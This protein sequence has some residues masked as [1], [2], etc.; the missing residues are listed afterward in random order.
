MKKAKSYVYVLRPFNGWV[1]SN[2]KGVFA[3]IDDVF[4]YFG[5]DVII[6]DAHETIIGRENLKELVFEGNCG[7]AV[8]KV[9]TPAFSIGG[10]MEFPSRARYYY[11]SLE[12]FF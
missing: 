4:N 5:Y 8:I 1:T 12:K 10:L 3:T 2:I 9:T 11:V 6:S 7:G